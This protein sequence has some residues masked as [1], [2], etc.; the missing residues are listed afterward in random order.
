MD[1]A[2]FAALVRDR[3]VTTTEVAAMLGLQ[4]R[5]AVRDRIK[6]GT[7]P[8]P[9]LLFYRVVALWDRATIERLIATDKKGDTE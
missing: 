1:E 2:K 8:P 9:I 4:T 3:L 6:A 7:L 5:Q